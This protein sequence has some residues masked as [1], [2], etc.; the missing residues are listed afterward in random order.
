MEGQGEQEK[1]QLGGAAS[2][3]CWTDGFAA[4]WGGLW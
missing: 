1:R 4:A 2:S 3:R